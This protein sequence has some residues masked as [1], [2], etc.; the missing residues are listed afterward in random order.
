MRCRVVE[1]RDC[2]DLEKYQFV[3]NDARI[4]KV[5]SSSN[6]HLSRAKSWTSTL[7]SGCSMASV[8]MMPVR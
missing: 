3:A 6:N 1:S 8:G 4:P 5:P 7:A 2:A